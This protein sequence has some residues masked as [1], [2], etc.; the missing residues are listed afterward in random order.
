[1]TKP[2]NYCA[3]AIL[4]LLALCWPPLRAEDAALPIDKPVDL[5]S[6]ATLPN[7]ELAPLF[8]AKVRPLLAEYCLGCHSTKLKKGELDLERFVSIDVARNDLKPWQSLIEMLDAG[9]MPPKGKRQPTAD[10]RKW[11]IEW[12]RRWLDVE[13][14]A[15]AGDPGHIALR[16]L[17][18]AE[19]NCTVRDL[20]GVDL[21]PAPSFP[22][23]A[24][25]A[26]V[27]P[28]PPKRSRCRRRWSTNISPPPRASP[29]MR[30]CC[31]MVF[32]FRRRPISTIGSTN[33]SA[34]CIGSTISSA[35]A[36]A[37]SA[38]PLSRRDDPKSSRAC[39]SL[40]N[41][42]PTWLGKKI[43]ARNIWKF[44]G[45][46]LTDARP[47]FVLDGIRSRWKT[48]GLNDVPAIVGQIESWQQVAWKLNDTAA[49]IY[50]PWQ[51]PELTVTDSQNLRI[52]LNPPPGQNEVVLYLVA[53]TIGA[54]RRRCSRW[55]SGTRRD[56][57]PTSSGRCC[58][59][60]CRRWPRDGRRTARSV[61]RYGQVSRGGGAVA[62]RRRCRF[63]RIDRQ[64]AFARCKAACSIGSTWPD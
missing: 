4:M 32:D 58:F 7:P 39:R 51:V 16:R 40:R 63:G 41:R 60:M 26:K 28:T 6:L 59:A 62:A 9:E 17:S 57:R 45:T 15:R 29:I 2:L 49:G 18:N 24:P 52:K 42:L 37:D 22:P 50:E 13:A 47:S 19:Y 5:V 54:G 38:A 8:A 31:P 20:T 55:F 56:S 64:T 25:R 36:T 61:P 34:T 53:R 44:F 11:L 12:T 46:R 30:S 21:Q 33:R 10:E 1:M 14:R 23:T 3:A 48:A 43:S 35:K 27:L